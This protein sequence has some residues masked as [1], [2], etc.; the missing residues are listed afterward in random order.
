MS[1]PAIKNS[2]ARSFAKTC[3]QMIRG[4]SANFSQTYMIHGFTYKK[5][6]FCFLN[7]KNQKESHLIFIFFM[8]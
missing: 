5:Y 3:F 2:W 4:S 6:N 8:V 7:A 1:S